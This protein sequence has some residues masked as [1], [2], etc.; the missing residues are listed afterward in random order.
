MKKLRLECKTKIIRKTARILRLRVDEHRANKLSNQSALHR[1]GVEHGH[2][3][4]YDGVE[5]IDMADSDRKLQYKELLHIIDR[6]PV[7]NK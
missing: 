7:I 5:L 3:I 1:H 4:E 2:E 6:K